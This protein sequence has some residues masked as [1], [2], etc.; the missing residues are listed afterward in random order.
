MIR[1]L[2]A[3]LLVA[4]AATGWYLY[5]RMQKARLAR[6]FARKRARDAIA[7]QK[8]LDQNAADRARGDANTARS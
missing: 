5:A 2:V 3:A 8:V 6:R 1:L 7:W 4:F